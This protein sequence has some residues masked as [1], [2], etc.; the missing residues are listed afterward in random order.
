MVRDIDDDDAGGG[1]KEMI[2]PANRVIPLPN[3]RADPRR[4]GHALFPKGAIVLALYP[5]TTCFYKGVVET[6]PAGPNDDYL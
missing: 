1:G 3:F 2:I 4:H 6:P 5:Q